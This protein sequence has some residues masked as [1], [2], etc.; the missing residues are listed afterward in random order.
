MSENPKFNSFILN[1]VRK[2]IDENELLSKG[3]KVLVA[4]SGGADSVSLLD[5]MCRLK[6]ELGITVGA[7]HLNHM[8]RGAEADRDEA[9]A[10]ELCTK[11][12]VPFYAERVD[13]P[14]LAKDS[15]ISE[16]TAGRNARYAFFAEVCKRYGYT[17]IATAHN[18]NDRAETV[19]MRIIR[20]TGTGGLGS[21]KYK[22]ENIVRPVLDLSRES[23]EEYCAKNGLRYCTDSTNAVN[24]Y[25]RNKIRNELIPQ[26]KKEFNPGI[27]DTLCNLADNSSEDAEFID[28]YAERLYRRINSPMP[29]RKPTVLDIK[30]LNMV[31]DGILNRLIRIACREVMGDDYNLER[32]HTDAV[33]N[34][35]DKETGASAT[36]PGGL[37]VN[38]KY[39]WLEFV[40]E[41]EEESASAL[42]KSFCY[43]LDLSDCSDLTM[44]DIKLEIVEGEYKPKKNQMIV[45]FDT[46]SEKELCIRS[47]KVG[48]RIVLYRDGKSRKLKDFFIDKKIPR[49]ER[50]NIPLLC[51]DKE[52]IAVIG[53]RV[54]E[55]YRVNKNTKRGLVITYGTGNENR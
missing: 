18:R 17:K 31:D 7:A 6:D 43:E 48:D 4:L 53:Y 5:I 26:I 1:I 12:S 27:I 11:L 19:L 44:D 30:S 24:D 52:V 39:G 20:G 2:T 16:E 49:N 42:K 51:S 29:H 21:I 54:A 32:V 25:T 47:R 50:G 37:K 33:K 36:L 8:I 40:S 55:N 9:Y 35:L 14:E 38:V 28:G 41:E 22:R 46:L 34:L 3:D 10:A 15:G 23:I 45:D 13:V